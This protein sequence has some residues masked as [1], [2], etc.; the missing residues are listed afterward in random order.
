[1]AETSDI[2]YLALEAI[3]QRYLRLS[4]LQAS[5]DRISNFITELSIF[6]YCSFG[7]ET[8]YGSV[9]WTKIRN[10]NPNHQGTLFQK[11]YRRGKGVVAYKLLANHIPL[12]SEVIGAHE[13]ESNFVFDICYN[14][15]INTPSDLSRIRKSTHVLFS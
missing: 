7:L 5:N 9:R 3:Y 11:N 15:T 6:P 1:M 2:P 12:Q 8:L 13:H 10:G 14:N 4:T